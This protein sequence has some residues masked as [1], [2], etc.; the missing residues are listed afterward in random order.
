MK[1]F[2]AVLLFVGYSLFAAET[3]FF[4]YRGRVSQLGLV[5]A[6]QTLSVTLRLY[7][8]TSS[9]DWAWGM[10]TD[11]VLDANGMF[12][13]PVALTSLGHY[14]QNQVTNLNSVSLQEVL[15]SGKARYLGVT[16][17][18]DAEQF[19]RQR[20][21]H[22]PLSFSAIVAER[23]SPNGSII[24]LSGAE[25]TIQELSVTQA[26][27]GT[28]KVNHSV[29]LTV[30]QINVP[31][32]TELSAVDAKNVKIFSDHG[33]SVSR[34]YASLAKGQYLFWTNEPGIVVIYS[35]DNWDIPCISWMVSGGTDIYAPVGC[36]GKTRIRFYRLGTSL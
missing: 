3:P 14:T 32:G 15:E 1:T 6:G 22:A 23:L 25:A 28:L 21:L 18:T 24:S 16:L 29:T 19:P 8:T 17:G 20:F 5:R 30:D 33:P 35:V 4:T 26:Q 31:D 13:I 34:E 2:Y 7:P 12:Q 10:Q 27:V 36:G 9:T 11:A